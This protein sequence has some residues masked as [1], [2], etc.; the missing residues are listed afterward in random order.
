MAFL[1]QG[2]KDPRPAAPE[3]TPS[4]PSPILTS[5]FYFA[6]AIELGLGL[7]AWFFAFDGRRAMT[8]VVIGPLAVV[9]LVALVLFGV[10]QAVHYLARTAMA[11]ERTADAAERTARATERSE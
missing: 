2:A 1:V 5:L 9:I 11:A 10:G 8:P 3:A 7:V 4:A 6:G